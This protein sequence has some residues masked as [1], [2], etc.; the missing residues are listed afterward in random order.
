MGWLR[1]IRNF[2]EV[3]L[4]KVKLDALSPKRA[5]WYRQVRIWMIAFS[6]FQKDKCSEKA[7]AL[8]YF[9]LLSIVPVLAM[10]YGIATAF[11]LQEAIQ[12]ELETYLTGQQAVA[13][14]V[15]IYA[16][17]M[18]A[19]S[20]GGVISGISA[21]F[22]IYSVAKL[23]NNIEGVFN[24]IWMSQ[25]SRSIKR[26]VTD[27]MTVIFL[28]PLILIVSSS[29]TVFITTSVE[30][31]A[32]SFALL[33]FFKPLIMSL[34]RL[35]PYTLI[36]FLLFLIYIIFPNTQVKVKPA[37]IAGVLAG[38]IF[39]VTQY[40]WLEGQVFLGRYNAIYG[41]FAAVPLFLIWLQLSWL[42][43]L[44][45]AEFAF[46]IQNV[47][48]WAFDS[49]ELK[50]NL[51]A[52]RKTT[53]LVLRAI[54]HHFAK[55][56]APISFEALCAQ[57]SIPRRFVRDVIEELLKTR[58]I[59]RVASDLEVE[60]YQPGMDVHKMDV[61]IVYDRMQKLGMDHLPQEQENEGYAEVQELI[62]EIDDA[63]RSA[64]RANRKLL[65]L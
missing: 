41:S 58:L 13:T 63:I 40:A 56:D 37:F 11:G 62:N 49:E 10:A 20:R 55:E 28:G 2:L 42:I 12:S 29:L 47:G 51:V 64:P 22:L 16:K 59:V 54:V 3:D 24:V 5:F 15:L 65:D 18:L 32:D 38:T 26:K 7:S 35:L 19:T 4:W 8:T 30:Q 25:E 23:L 6:E 60:Q 36:W 34:V 33:G 43:V 39:Q 45:G 53:L 14:N 17:E 1:K 50:M 31:I 21:L 48:T 46:S 57:M 61:F 52:R 9:S 44:F 27:Y